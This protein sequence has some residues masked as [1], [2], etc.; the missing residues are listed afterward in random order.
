[1]SRPGGRRLPAEGLPPFCLMS[2][3]LRTPPEEIAILTP[4]VMAALRLVGG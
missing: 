3:A 2:H 1:M 4:E